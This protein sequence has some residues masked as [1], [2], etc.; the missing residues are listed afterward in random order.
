V[1][2]TALGHRTRSAVRRSLDEPLVRFLLIGA[3]LFLVFDWWNV[4]GS[5][6]IVITPGQVD[7]IE[8]GFARTWQRAPTADELKHLVDEHVREEIATREAMSAGLDRDDTI[9]RRRLRQK[10]EF[11]AEEV[12][13]ASPPA[14]AELQRWLD[15]HP[16]LYRTEPTLTLRQVVLTPDRRG[17]S[18]DR[19]ARTT[20]A[21]LTA[22]GPD[23]PLDTLTD[24]RML[25]TELE[26]TTAS[27]LARRF[28]QEFAD[29]CVAAT[30]GRWTGPHRSGH[31][32]HVVFVRAR[33][34]ARVPSL[35]EVRLQ[36]MRDVTTDRRKRSIEAMYDRLLA[37]YQVVVAPRPD[38]TA[39]P[40]D[41][42]D[43]K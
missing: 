2:L 8:A 43:T 36:V 38:R 12:I 9:V 13:E 32:L 26:T 23:A 16:E 18:L 40:R 7:A 42:Q 10:L 39:S 1:G 24:S 37:R 14:E 5:G 41:P 22:A 30:P 3:A 33:E 11:L 17:S 6:R 19:D 28:G 4:T 21:R 25:P 31:G 29:A 35:A 15:R 27:D 20:L 34:A